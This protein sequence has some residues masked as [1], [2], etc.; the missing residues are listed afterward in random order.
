MEDPV[1]LFS[2]KEAPPEGGV[3]STERRRLG[4]ELSSPWFPAFLSALVMGLGQLYNGQYRAFKVFLGTELCLILYSYDYWISH[5]VSSVVSAWTSPFLYGL[6]MALLLG[7]GFLVWIYNIYDAY[8]TALFCRMIFERTIPSLEDDDEGVNV[9]EEGLEGGLF[10]H[11]KLLFTGAVLFVYSFIVFMVGHYVVGGNERESAASITAGGMERLYLALRDEDASR[12]PRVVTDMVESDD[13]AVRIALYTTL[14]RRLQ[15]EGRQESAGLL[16]DMAQAELRR[17]GGDAAPA[18][19]DAGDGA[20]AGSAAGG[21]SGVREDSAGDSSPPRLER[22]RGE[23]GS[24][25]VRRPAAEDTAPP[26]DELDEKRLREIMDA[27]GVAAA[28]AALVAAGVREP[29][30]AASLWALLVEE[31]SRRGHHDLARRWLTEALTRCPSSPGLLLFSFLDALERGER[32]EAAEAASAF[33]REGGR[34]SRVLRF[35]LDRAVALRHYDE[36]LRYCSMLVVQEPSSVAPLL[37]KAR[38]LQLLGRSGEALRQCLDVL[39][40]RPDCE[41]ARWLGALLAVS[42]G[43]GGIEC[44]D[45]VRKALLQGRVPDEVDAKLLRSL[46]RAFAGKGDF[47]AALSAADAALEKEPRDVASLYEKG[48]LLFEAGRL[49]QAYELLEQVDSI[50]PGYEQVAYFLGRCA[51]KT[52]KPERAKA[53]YKRVRNDSPHFSDAAA[54]LRRLEKVAAQADAE[55][56]AKSPSSVVRASSGERAVGGGAGE[57]TSVAAASSSSP[58]AGE[59]PAVKVDAYADSLKRAELAYRRGDLK[60]AL[61]WYERVLSVY[62]SHKRS[63]YQKAVILRD[64]GRVDEALAVLERAVRYHP[65]D[66]DLLMEYG[67]LLAD[68]ERYME[69]VEVFRKVVERS[70]RNLAAR[71]TLGWLY[72]KL[73]RYSEA[74]RHYE[75]IIRYYPE[76]TKAYEYLGN[77]YFHEKRFADAAAAFRKVLELDPSDATVRFKLAVTLLRADRRREAEGELKRLDELLP[78][79]HPLRAKVER[80][81]ERLNN[82]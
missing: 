65:D 44:V 25:V 82:G 76:Y 60:D 9:F 41:E 5:D 72:E 28:H 59:V 43:K 46:A 13:P 34:D 77:V 73:K 33:L 6:F 48:R 12:I 58:S 53:Y 75:A 38:I 57:R 16:L 20:A 50:A 37:K 79:E 69:A 40:R 56:P 21:E 31:T 19:N 66:P 80:Y 78:E 23:G 39:R 24:A 27:R 70:P 2:M 8:T 29:V 22:G 30:R 7:C 3:R 81:L 10:A 71:Y 52:G 55:S 26:H 14:A 18:E 17:L 49:S 47:D 51:E 32:D 74:E 67:N 15:R 63:L 11:K 35:L 4:R 45:E 61:E 54:G 1:E 62:P 36:A 68:K 42:C 64:T